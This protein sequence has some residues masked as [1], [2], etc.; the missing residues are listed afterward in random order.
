M[1]FASGG[2]G[3]A[4]GVKAMGMLAEAREAGPEDGN[5]RELPLTLPLD[6]PKGNML[7]LAPAPSPAAAPSLLVPLRN[8]LPA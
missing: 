5:K 2:D 8:A 3:V 7:P 4:G 6:Q 1:K